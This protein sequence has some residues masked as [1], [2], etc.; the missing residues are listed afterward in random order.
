MAHGALR[1]RD[2][3][4]VGMRVAQRER[5]SGGA[6]RRRE[7]SRQ[8]CHGFWLDV[9]RRRRRINIEQRRDRS[10]AD[11]RGCSHR[12][13]A[14]NGMVAKGSRAIYHVWCHA[15]VYRGSVR[16]HLG[17]A[18][19]GICFRASGWRRRHRIVC[20]SERGTSQGTRTCIGKRRWHRRFIRGHCFGF[21][22]RESRCS[23][24]CTTLWSAFGPCKRHV[25]GRANLRSAVEALT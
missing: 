22:S 25:Y 8:P 2:E 13:R 3:H 15:S 16:S 5:R 4:A 14:G 24:S 18:G 11:H 19:R 7:E 6:T 10:V 20:L 12:H 17:T 21:K 9:V 23:D 1:R